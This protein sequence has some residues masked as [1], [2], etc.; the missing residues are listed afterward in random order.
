MSNSFNYIYPDKVALLDIYEVITKEYDC[1]D[2]CIGTT[3]EHYMNLKDI[4]NIDLMIYD[5]SKETFAH[6][7]RFFG[8]DYEI[9]VSRK[10]GIM[11][12]NVFYVKLDNLKV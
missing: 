4:E 12:D 7:Y 9:T 5:A 3:I 8:S 6:K 2:T 10:R 11:I 1:D